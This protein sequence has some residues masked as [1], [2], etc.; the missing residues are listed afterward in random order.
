MPA[1][2]WRRPLLLSAVAAGMLTPLAAAPAHAAPP[3]FRVFTPVNA[4]VGLATGLDG[5]VWATST[6]SDSIVSITPQGVSTLIPTALLGG[7][8]GP[9][10]ITAGPDGAMWFT[11]NDA[12]VRFEG[13]GASSQF[14]VP[15]PNSG[16]GTITAGADGNLWYTQSTANKIGCITPSGTAC[17]APPGAPNEFPLPAGSTPAD[18]A[19]GSDG[20]LWFT[21][22]GANAI[23]TITPAGQ[24]TQRGLIR[25][26]AQPLAITAGADGNLWF[27]EAGA[28]FIGT[29][30]TAGAAQDFPISAPAGPIT[31]GSDGNVWFA[32]ANQPTVGRITPAGVV[33]EFP[34]TGL[35]AGTAMLDLRTGPDGNLWAST[36]N[37]KV[38]RVTTGVTPPRFT[39]PAQIRLP[40]TGDSGIADPYPATIEA[41]GLQGTVTKVTVRL[42]GVHHGF[43]RDIQAQLVGPQGQSAM[44]MANPTDRLGDSARQPDVL[45]GD[46]LTFS[47]GA[48][49]P[50]RRPTTGVFAPSDSGFT[51]AFVPPAPLTA[52]P[53]SLAVFNGTNPNGAW[54]LFLVDDAEYPGTTRLNA[55]VIAGGWSLDIQTTGPPPVQLPAADPIIVPGPTVTVAGQGAP[56]PVADIT[57]PTLKLAKLQTRMKLR[58]FR[59]GVRVQVTPSEPVTLDTTLFVSP[60]L[61]FDRTA[62]LRRTQTV[63]VKPSAKLL[64]RQRG[65]FRV[66]L[67]L[68]ATDGAANRTTVQRTITVRP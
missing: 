35:P 51:L 36:G 47:D 40:G 18:I 48:P 58:D 54:K 24:V 2:A 33:T 27:T 7:A 14:S 29:I 6:A 12:I 30:T 50:G 32:L 20:N 57:R 66:R 45:D 46:V 37:G 31:A 16:L 21:M 28:A 62:K 67:R 53:A 23:G 1:S 65:T 49:A 59:K 41:D 13:V 4:P 55:G 39:D 60:R 44:L 63:V 11:A 26:G 64:G 43:A 52:P 9:V 56:A 17:V 5:N 19:A 38:V 68:V 10:A 22:S 25:P 34:I 3:S 8:S 61:V 15:T 42:N